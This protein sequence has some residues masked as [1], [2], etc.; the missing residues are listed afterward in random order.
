MTKVKVK[1]D[2]PRGWHYIAAE[3]YDPSIHQLY[4]EPSYS[5]PPAPPAP[6][7][8]VSSDP[9]DNLPPDWETMHGTRLKNLAAAVGGGRTVENVEQ[10]RA[11]IRQALA[12]RGT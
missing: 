5:P 9:L 1:R 4:D 8:Q 12:A 2:G 6:P 10:A 7:A 3:N 11:V